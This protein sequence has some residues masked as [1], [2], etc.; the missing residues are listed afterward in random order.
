[1]LLGALLPITAS[2]VLSREQ[3]TNLLKRRNFAYALLVVFLAAGALRASLSYKAEFFRAVY[4]EEDGWTDEGVRRM[5]GILGEHDQ[6]IF[7][8]FLADAYLLKQ[9]RPEQAIEEFKKGC[10][11]AKSDWLA[12]E[13]HTDL[14]RAY[15]EVKLLD[16][17]IRELEAALKID[18]NYV[19]AVDEARDLYNEK[20]KQLLAAERY[21]DAVTAAQRSI[22]VL[23][24]YPNL[25]AYLTL[26]RARV[27]QRRYDDARIWLK[28]AERFSDA[29]READEISLLLEAQKAAKATATIKRK[30]RSGGGER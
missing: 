28:K 29:K 6:P 27:L 19:L 12:L 14:G 18:N 3:K 26:A 7:H 10:I 20:A 13:C 17:A 1:L 8:L 2:Q 24:E 4:L 23:E 11:G 22:E 16:D 21:E 25:E 5:E 15:H 9:H 30:P